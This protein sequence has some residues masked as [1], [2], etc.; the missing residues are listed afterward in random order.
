MADDILLKEQIGT[1][2]RL[3]LNRPVAR[4]SLSLAML[5]ALF[6]VVTDLGASRDVHVI[7]LAAN[8]PGFCA[9]HDL[10]ELTAA[11]SRPDRGKAFFEDAMARCSRLMQAIV[12]CPKPVIAEANGIATAAGCQLVAICSKLLRSIT[13]SGRRTL[14]S[15]KRSLLPS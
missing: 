12:T 8:G 7:I 15:V 13:R 1:V 6:E 10:K 4:N 2:A 9:G 14:S 11:R 5:D 3:V